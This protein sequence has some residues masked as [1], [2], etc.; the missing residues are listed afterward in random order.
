MIDVLFA[1]A[2]IAA[3]APQAPAQPPAEAAPAIFMVHDQDTTIY[4]F[5]TFHA[6]DGRSEWLSR[7]VKTAF[8]SSD[9]LVLETLIP[10]NH[11]VPAA[12][13]PAFSMSAGTP[14]V[15]LSVAPTA[16]FL[17][18]TRLAIDAGRSQGMQVGNGADMV[19]RRAAELAGKQLEGLETL[20]SQLTM[21]NHMPSP[22]SAAEPR[23]GAPVSNAAAM[24]ALSSTMAELQSAWKRGDQSMFVRML[25]QLRKS[26]PDT[27]R[28]MFAERNARWA[29]WIAARMQTPGVVFVAVGAGH[30]AG[31]D[32]VLVRLAQLGVTSSRIN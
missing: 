5:G 13:R 16:S 11:P 6:L 17:A 30:L 1:A 8:D 22:A 12:P 7:T 15:T 23:A 32:S 29:D 24:Q 3:A 25:D 14:V 31:K 4:I 21:F 18:T 26:S 2:A 28:L 9:E 20:D 10:E 27:Y 19:L